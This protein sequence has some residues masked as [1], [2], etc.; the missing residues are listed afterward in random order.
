MVVRAESSSDPLC[1]TAMD[2]RNAGNAGAITSGS[3]LRARCLIRGWR[4]CAEGVRVE[5]ASDPLAFDR[6]YDVHG[7]TSAVEHRDVRE[8]PI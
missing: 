6:S 8:R 1:L 2:G 4:L 7:C 3:A 5:T